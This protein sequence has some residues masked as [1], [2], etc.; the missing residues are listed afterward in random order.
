MSANDGAA[1]LAAIAAVPAA[2]PR[3]TLGAQLAAVINGSSRLTLADVLERHLD[4]QLPAAST[5]A[6]RLLGV[7]AWA[8][9]AAIPPSAG[10]AGDV[11]SG[12]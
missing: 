10:D 5:D 7:A 6:G 8:H 4:A 12:W 11:P 2:W 3:Q 1:L 9:I